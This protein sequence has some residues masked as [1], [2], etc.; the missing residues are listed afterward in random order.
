MFGNV[1][2]GLDVVKLMEGVGSRSG[3]TSKPVVIADCGVL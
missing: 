3:A 2:A 1:T